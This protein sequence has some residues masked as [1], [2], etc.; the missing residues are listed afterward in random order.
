MFR[1]QASQRRVGSLSGTTRRVAESDEEYSDEPRPPPKRARVRPPPPAAPPKAAAPRTL[2]ETGEED[3]IVL[4]GSKVDDDEFMLSH[5]QTRVHDE[6]VAWIRR[7]EERACVVAAPSGVGKKTIV[8]RALQTA[9]V[10]WDGVDGGLVDKGHRVGDTVIKGMSISSLEAF[11]SKGTRKSALLVYSADAIGPEDAGAI[12]RALV[13][14]ARRPRKILFLV[15]DTGAPLPLQ[16]RKS[17]AVKRITFK[18]NAR[19]PGVAATLARRAGVSAEQA[20]AALEEADGNIARAKAALHLAVGMASDAGAV[21]AACDASGLSQNASDSIF[22]AT[23]DLLTH[24]SNMEHRRRLAKAAGGEE[25]LALAAHH[26]ILHSLDQNASWWRDTKDPP[27]KVLLQ[28]AADMEQLADLADAFALADIKN[29]PAMAVD[30]IGTM[31]PELLRGC[32]VDVK[33]PSETNASMRRAGFRDEQTKRM[34]QMLDRT[35]FPL[36]DGLG[37][38]VCLDVNE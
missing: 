36:P 5:V 37:S 18:A 34:R 32:R 30:A 8:Q 17:P 24:P 3:F 10:A 26:S 38:A 29:D 19:D 22:G 35:F 14:S 1:R 12:A 15:S 27:P 7:G 2:A 28:Q 9:G 13:Q 16:L 21:R 4:P 11:G 23:R 33:Y 6:V 20:K 31:A 25:R